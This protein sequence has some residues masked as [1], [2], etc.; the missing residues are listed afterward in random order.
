STGPSSVIDAPGLPV[1]Q[2]EDDSVAHGV[3]CLNR[4]ALHVH[5]AIPEI[6]IDQI[7]VKRKLFG[8]LK[9]GLDLPV[10]L[11]FELTNARTYHVGV[12]LIAFV[13]ESR[14]AGTLVPFEV[15]REVTENS[16]R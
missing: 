4:H 16:H 10:M 6:G 15:D 14:S 13:R 1:R 7:W 11:G 8:M 12:T 5:P 3:A 2:V 9:P